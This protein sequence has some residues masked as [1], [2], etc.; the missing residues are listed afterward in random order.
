MANKRHLTELKKGSENWNHW[1]ASHP[2]TMPDLRYASLSKF[3]LPEV[4]LSGL[5]LSGADLSWAN[6]YS[7]NIHSANLTGVDLTNA[8]LRFANLSHANLSGANLSGADFS[9]ATIGWTIFSDVDLS[10]VK[11]LHRV[12]HY[13]PSSIGVDTLYRSGRDIPDKF[14]RGCGLLD[15][16]ITCYP[17]CI[18]TQ[19]ASQFYTCFISY[20]Q[21]DEE[22]AKHLHAHL[23]KAGIPVWFAPENLNPG[24]KLKEQIEQAIRLHQKLLLVLSEHSINSEWVKTE[25]RNARQAEL[26][27]GQRKIFPIRLGEWDTLLAWKFLD[28]DSGQDLA[29]EVREYYMLDFSS[30]GDQDFFER[31]FTR[32][33]KALI[34]SQEKAAT[35]RNST[36]E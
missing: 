11:H 10:Q 6:L 29:V 25:I 16:F 23:R 36:A 2:K 24:G 5:D 26:E 21:K 1:R 4:D 28:S 32:L 35:P 31:E 15:D 34:Q 14:L 30:W 12:T 13:G 3:N 27:T 20:N 33:L 17:T 18:N 8:N 9:D 22:F 7:A 19:S